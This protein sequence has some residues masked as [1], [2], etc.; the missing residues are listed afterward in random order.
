MSDSL[1]FAHFL[2]FGERCEWIAHFAQIKWAMWANRSFCSPKMSDS[3][4]SLRGNEQCEQIA[5]FT[6]QKWVNRSFFWAN[7]SFAHYCFLDKKRAICSEIEWVNSQPWLDSGEEWVGQGRRMCRTA[8]KNG[9]DSGEGINP[10]SIFCLC[11][12]SISLCWVYN[13]HFARGAEQFFCWSE[14]YSK[15]GVY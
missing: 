12:F 6:H 14:T 4:K 7:R 13:T 8:E 15:V 5:H 11:C 3:L 10:V 1:I 2:F 9:W